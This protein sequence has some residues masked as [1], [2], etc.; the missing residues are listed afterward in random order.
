MAGKILKAKLWDD[1]KG[2]RWKCNVQDIDGEVLC[3]MSH[4]SHTWNHRNNPSDQPPQSLNSL[5]WLL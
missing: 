2:G 4:P 1:D 3:G 5:S